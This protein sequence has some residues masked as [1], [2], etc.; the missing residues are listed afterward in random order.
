M[1]PGAP[2][3]SAEWDA[4]KARIEEDLV[5]ID[6]AA[7]EIADSLAKVDADAA[8]ADLK[9]VLDS[10][11]RF[12]FGEVEILGIEHYS[13]S[14]VRRAGRPASR[15]ALQRRAAHRSCSAGCRTARG[16]RAW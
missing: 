3:R 12:T 9:L 7:G 1:K 15:G 14:I 2:F 8:R 10:G 4:A 6:Y 5:Q 16:S 13:E 11:P